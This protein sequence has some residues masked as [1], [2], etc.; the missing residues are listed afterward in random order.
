M[1]GGDDVNLNISNTTDN[2][3]INLLNLYFIKINT[4]VNTITDKHI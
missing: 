2:Y 1:S 3:T 4:I